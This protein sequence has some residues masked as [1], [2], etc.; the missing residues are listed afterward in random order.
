[1]NNV[2]II[3]NLEYSKHHL[4]KSYYHSVKNLYGTPKVIDKHNPIQSLEGV[5]LLFIGDDH[6]G[7]HKDIWLQTP[8]FIE[9][10]N[11]HKIH[12]VALTNERILDSFFPWNKE[13]FIQLNKFDNLTHYANDVDDCN[14]LGLKLNRQAMSRSFAPLNNFPEKKNKVVFIGAI[15]CKSYRER[16][17]VLREIQK[18]IEVDII[19][20]DIPTWEE[21]MKTIAQYRF[22]LSPIGNGNFFP[23][24]FYEALAVGSIPIHQVRENTL[25]MYDIEAQYDDCIYFKEPSELKKKISNF[26]SLTSHNRLWMEDNLERLLKE[27]NLL[28]WKRRV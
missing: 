10:C 7:P 19:A 21:Y 26:T 17:I 18:E 4:F 13:N 9:E 2:G 25:T 5:E 14:K 24:R 8:N 6:F 27:D 1:M 20:S 22:V 12:I 11:K 28:P 23:M 15:K 3:C 16:N